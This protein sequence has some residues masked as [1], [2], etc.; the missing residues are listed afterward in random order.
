MALIKCPECSKQISDQ[1]ASCPHCG[2]ILTPSAEYSVASAVGPD[3]SQT[4]EHIQHNFKQVSQGFYQHWQAQSPIYRFTVL[5]SLAGGFI[6]SPIA[7]AII[8]SL[9]FEFEFKMYAVILLCTVAGAFAGYMV[10]KNQS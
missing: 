10:S 3:L 9:P 1:A 7:L 4:F 8:F 5:G 6:I 2:Y